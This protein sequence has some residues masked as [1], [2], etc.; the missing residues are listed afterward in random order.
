M[1]NCFLRVIMIISKITHV[2]FHENKETTILYFFLLTVAVLIRIFSNC[3]ANVYQKKLTIQGCNPISINAITYFLLAIVSIVLVILFGFG[4]VTRGFWMYAALVG[5][6]GALGNGFLIKSLEKGELSVLGPINAYK[7]VVGLIFGML[8]L[9]EMPN[10]IGIVGMVLIIAGSYFVL[11][12]LEERFSWALLKNK[13]IQYRFY[14]LFFSAVEAVFIKKLI[15]MSSI[16]DAFIVWCIFGA[17]FALL[18]VKINKLSFVQEFNVL[19]TRN[20]AKFFNIV[21]CIGMMQYTTNYVFSKMDV[22]Y[23]LSLFQL[24]ALVSVFLG[25]KFFMEKNITKKLL[26]SAIMITGAVLIILFN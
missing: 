20:A 21:V 19:K 14:A 1:A 23:A 25:Y 10:L 3:L 6:L 16:L 11:D 18:M 4:E 13:Q 24:C 2:G 17:V 8:F 9:K 7:A 12:T 26:G 15:L 5:L 22:A